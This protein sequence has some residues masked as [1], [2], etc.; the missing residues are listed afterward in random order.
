MRPEFFI[1]GRF[2][3]MHRS[4][5]R[6]TFIVLIAVLGIALGTA[7]LILTLSI[8]NGFAGSIEG[9]LVSFNSHMQFRYPN[10]RLFVERRSDINAIRSHS[11]ITEASP[12][13]E[14]GCILMSSNGKKSGAAKSQPVM[15]KGLTPEAGKVFLERY[16][17][18]ESPQADPNSGFLE[19]YPGRTLA[20][21][22]N[23]KP[24]D[25]VM[26][27]G[28]DT[29]ANG[30]RAEQGGVVGMLSSLDI[31]LGT[32]KG[33]YDT[34]LQEGFDDFLILTDLSALQ[35]HYAPGMISGYD[36]NTS[37]LVSVATTAKQVAASLG[38]PFYGYT[39]FERYQ[40]LFEWLKLQKNITPLL[41]LTITI[42]AVFNIIATL[43][44]L[45]IEKTREIG[46]LSAIGMVPSRISNVFMGQAFLIALAGIVAGNIL[47]FSLTVLELRFHFITLPEKSYF[48]TH[49]PLT[50][51]PFDY[52][53][54]SL[55]VLL[56]TL[57]FAFIPARVAAA[58]KP[59]TALAA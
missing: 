5:S 19:L 1:A 14:K 52:G 24:G 33:I 21:K 34:G 55:S 15:V 9:K 42:V 4:L 11:E 54:V 23:L 50:L 56:L 2:A 7:A 31:E 37:S 27:V 57:L 41:I 46:L 32:I 13:L 53:A 43:L 51:N 18:I 44:V 3:F 59:G 8:V 58:L 49:V 45:V 12:F 47:A 36:A 20:E 48:I 38:Y 29:A 40:N 6:P 30:E 16:L 17:R 28:L 22:L 25:T 39:V 10:E 26:L 35:A